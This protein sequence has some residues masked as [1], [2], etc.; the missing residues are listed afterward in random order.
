MKLL[1]LSAGLLFLGGAALSAAAQAD[2]P[3]VAGRVVAADGGSVAG[4]RVVLSDGAFAESA[5]VGSDGRFVLPLPKGVGRD[6]L[7]LAVREGDAAAA[8]YHPA[9]VRVEAKDVDEGQDFVLVPREWT[10]PAGA[11]AGE[12]VEI[13]PRLAFAPVCDGC[14]AFLRRGAGTEAGVRTWPEA[15]FPLRVVFDREFSGAPVT[16]RDSVW[17]WRGAEALERDFGA[18]LVRPARFSEAAAVGDS[19]PN[20]IIYVQIDPSLRAAGLGV[21]GAYGR[22]IV[23]GEVRLQRGSLLAEPSGAGLV[24]HELLHALG[25]GHTCSWRSVMALE[26]RC[27]AK[28]APRATAEDVAYAQVVRRVRE[29]QREHG[30]RWGLEAA[31]A[32]EESRPAAAAPD[33]REH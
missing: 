20:D 17:F 19:T 31:L 29:L 8:R 9:E 14:S 26:S 25:F 27:P 22:D 2:G 12:R 32:G 13:S 11:Y 21:S 15:F 30:A 33:A 1:I 6:G 16:A 28:R 5:T 24:A 3:A 23:Y 18:R 10:I 4:V 7:T